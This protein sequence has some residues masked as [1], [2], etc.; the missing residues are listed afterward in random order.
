MDEN[1]NMNLRVRLEK[2]ILLFPRNLV[3]PIKN[4]IIGCLFGI[5]FIYAA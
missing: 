2:T 3:V 5:F 1:C 4:K